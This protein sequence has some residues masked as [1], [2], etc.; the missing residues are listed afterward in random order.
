MYFGENVYKNKKGRA[1]NKHCSYRF[2]T[3][4]FRE[5]NCYCFPSTV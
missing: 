1:K 2:L 3:R 5:L 4:P